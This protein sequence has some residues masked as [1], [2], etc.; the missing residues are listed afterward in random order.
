MQKK[1][2][3]KK[4][5]TVFQIIYN[6]ANIYFNL[7]KDCVHSIIT[8]HSPLSISD[9]DTSAMSASLVHDSRMTPDR[10]NQSRDLSG[11]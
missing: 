3:K 4:R 2:K 6:K 9:I 8:T 10:H 11:N 5:Y 7:N 1:K